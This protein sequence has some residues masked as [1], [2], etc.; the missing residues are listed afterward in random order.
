MRVILVAMAVVIHSYSH[1]RNCEEA[2]YVSTGGK[3]Y[4]YSLQWQFR[5]QVVAG[6]SE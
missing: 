1:N 6:K 2:P 5:D 4:Y 3:R